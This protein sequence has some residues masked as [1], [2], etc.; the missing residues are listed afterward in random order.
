L[1][2]IF[3][4]Y[5]REEQP[6]AKALADALERQGW[7]VWWDPKLRA[8]E[9]FDD[10][11]EKALQESKCVIVLWSKRSVESRYVRDEATYAL[12]R[13][14]L[15]PAA[16]EDVGP[17]FRFEGLQTAQLHGWD[18]SVTF[19]GFQKLVDDI[20]SV[21]G[22]PPAG[23]AKEEQERKAKTK[24]ES[25]ERTEKGAGKAKEKRRVGISRNV[26]LAMAG[27]LI[28]FWVFW[29]PILWRLARTGELNMFVFLFITL[30]HALLPLVGGVL[31]VVKSRAATYVFGTAA[32][33]GLLVLFVRPDLLLLSLI[34]IALAACACIFSARYFRPPG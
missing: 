7:S 28:A 15:I 17:P 5:K 34:T 16:I 2:D 11:I 1:S 9:H 19:P 32:L 22:S 8:G 25:G 10:V 27:V 14:K 4:S 24:P 20:R 21:I 29:G 23:G 31:V 18:G 33:C 6:Q 30:S 13:E 26:A 12:K 3:I